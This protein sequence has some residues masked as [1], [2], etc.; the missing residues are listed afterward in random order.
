[1]RILTPSRRPARN[2]SAGGLRRNDR[3]A[4]NQRT[5]RDEPARRTT[6]GR[7]CSAWRAM[8]ARDLQQPAALNERCRAG[9]TCGER[10]TKESDEAEAAR[11][12]RAGAERKAFLCSLTL[13]LS[14]CRRR[15]TILAQTDT[16]S[17]LERI[18]RF[19]LVRF[20]C[21]VENSAQG[22]CKSP[23]DET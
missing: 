1:M 13:E 11:T 10:R 8:S 12:L 20:V 4:P 19:S 16:G 3:A 18:V 23:Q 5:N 6:Q 7:A 22:K 21:D 9:R 15:R 17:P 2:D 14:G